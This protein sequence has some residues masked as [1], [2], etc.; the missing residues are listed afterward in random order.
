MT[1]ATV[2]TAQT[3]GLS[4]TPAASSFSSNPNFR[5]FQIALDQTNQGGGAHWQIMISEGWLTSGSTTTYVHPD[6]S[7]VV[8]FGATWDLATSTDVDAT[9]SAMTTN[10][11]T[12]LKF[13]LSKSL[14]YNSQNLDPFDWLMW[15]KFAA[16]DTAKLDIANQFSSFTW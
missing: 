16:S 7:G 5:G 13:V 3:T 4:Y 2:S 6:F 11:G 10:N 12:G 15:Q 14:G 8:G 1:G 9:V